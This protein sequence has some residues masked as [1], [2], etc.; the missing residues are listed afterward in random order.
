MV[1]KKKK[2]TPKAEIWREK[3]MQAL[4]D[5]VSPRG[6]V[7]EDEISR[8]FPRLQKNPRVMSRFYRLL[9]DSN[10]KICERGDF[11]AMGEKE[12]KFNLLNSIDPV[13]A[14]LREIGKTE[15]IDADEEKELSKKID[16]GDQDAKEKL[17]CANLRLVVSIAKKYANRTSKLSLLD[18]VQE[19][20]LGLFRAAEKFDWR[21]GYKFSTYATWWIRQA[22][23]RALANYARTIRIPVHMI[24]KITHYSKVKKDLQKTLGRSPLPEEIATEMGIPIEKVHQIMEISREVVSLEKPVGKDDQDSTLL[25]F[26]TNKDAPLPSDPAARRLLRERIKEMLTNLTPREKKILIMRF[27]LDDGQSRTLEEV[28]E[29]FKVTRER[30]RQI[31]VKALEKIRSEECLKKIEDY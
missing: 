1:T 8:V 4:V 13:Q 31:Q 6:F 17:V 19:G 15:L 30:I 26:I 10:V 11:L 28:G 12:E 16:K 23:T 21:R 27:G 9:E 24:E 20:N 29:E 2:Q 22:V 18:L 14:Y 7:T 25:E 3:K 5:K